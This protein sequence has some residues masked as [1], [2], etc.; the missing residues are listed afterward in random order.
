MLYLG[1]DQ[2]RNQLTVDLGNEQGDLV[3]HRQVSTAPQQLKA[4]FSWLNEASESEDG[5]AAILEV[6]GFNDYLIKL[7]EEYGCREIVLI[8]PQKKSRRK[9]DRRDARALRELLWLNRVPLMNGKHLAG[10]RRVR[11]CTQQEAEQRQITSLRKHLAQSTTRVVNKIHHIVLK[12]NLQHDCPTKSIDTQRARKWLTE[13]SLPPVD[14]LELDLMLARWQQLVEQI[15]Q[16]QQ[17][18]NQMVSQS[19]PAKI[20]AS[21]PGLRGYSSLAIASRIGNPHDFPRPASLANF[22]GLTPECSNSGDQQ[23]L[24]SITK[25]G[26]SLVRAL[27]G[28]C[29]YHVLRKDPWLREWYKRIKRRRGSGI[30]RVAV[31]R[32][33]MTIIWIMLREQVPYVPGG[34]TEVDK[35]RQIVR[36]LTPAASPGE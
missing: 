28:N 11:P 35:Q 33:L 6:C 30:A 18:V 36:T 23:R 5:F 19:S 26:S 13:L 9:T 7:L 12:H 21:I 34:P 32:R 25:Q 17:K 2:H 3:K 29:V 24:G 4:F 10:L 14:R 27:L 31:M 8:Q 20:V 1:I 15:E 22:F 16:V